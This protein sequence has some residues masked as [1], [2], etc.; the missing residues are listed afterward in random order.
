M[1]SINDKLYIQ[2]SDISRLKEKIDRA[3]ELS[4]ELKTTLDDLENYRI[5]FEIKEKREEK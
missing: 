1:F 2:T 3:I 5:E 4:R